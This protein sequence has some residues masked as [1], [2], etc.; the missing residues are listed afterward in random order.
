MKSDFFSEKPI[1]SRQ[2]V[3]S[4]DNLHRAILEIMAEDGKIIITEATT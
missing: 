4:L 1:L 3:N 2:V